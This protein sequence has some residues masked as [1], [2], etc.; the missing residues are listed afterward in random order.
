M[1]I[2]S[3]QTCRRS[4]EVWLGASVQVVFS[5]LNGKAVK[6]LL[7]ESNTAYDLWRVAMQPA[8]T[9]PTKMYLMLTL[10]FYVTPSSQWTTA[11]YFELH[12]GG[13]LIL[14]S[15]YLQN[16]AKCHM[17][18]AFFIWVNVCQYLRLYMYYFILFQTFTILLGRLDRGTTCCHIKSQELVRTC[19]DW[20]PKFWKSGWIY[21]PLFSMFLFI[22]LKFLL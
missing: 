4:K 5:C 12:Q 21:I 10:G 16:R 2:W 9:N 20:T 14:C 7:V 18:F 15:Q 3:R 6:K 17:D 13:Q 22:S 8:R 11:R 19:Q 1:G